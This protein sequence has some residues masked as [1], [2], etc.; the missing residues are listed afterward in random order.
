MLN[1]CNSIEMPPNPNKNA[2]KIIFVEII[3]YG[4][5]LI[6]LTPFV[7]SII[8]DK[9]PLQKFELLIPQNLKIGSNKEDANASILLF[10]SMDKTTLNSTTKPPIINIVLVAEEI[11]LP[12]TSP[13]F[14][15]ETDEEFNLL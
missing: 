5:E 2:D 4:I 10:S 8:P 9:K 13:K 3:L 7:N 15:K 6:I 14:E 12:K 1:T 11:D